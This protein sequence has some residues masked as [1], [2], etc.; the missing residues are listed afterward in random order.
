VSE[1]L[2][3]QAVHTFRLSIPFKAGSASVYGGN[4]N[5]TNIVVS[6]DTDTGIV[7]W[8]SAAFS[9]GDVESGYETIH[10]KLAPALM[11]MLSSPVGKILESLA[12]IEPEA[13]AAH[14]ALDI[15]IHDLWGKQLNISLCSFLGSYRNT[16]VTSAT[17]GQ[18]DIAETVA[19]A[20]KYTEIG[21]KALKIICGDE[22]EKEIERVKA[23]MKEYKAV[24]VRLFVGDCYNLKQSKK[25]IEAL[26]GNIELYEQAV[27][28]KTIDDFAKLAADSSVPI[29]AVGAVHSASEA[30]AVFQKEFSLIGLK[31]AECGG[32]AEAIRI[33]NIA[34][35]LGKKIVLGCMEEIPI[36]M[37]AAAHLALSHPA[38]AYT[39][40]DGH[41]H[42][43]QHAASNGIV[44]ENGMVSVVDRPGLG[45]EVRK[46]YL[47][48]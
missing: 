8:G 47:R 6:M 29:V 21:F 42:L 17:I 25:I 36:S 27:T 20:G 45:V 15:A 13:T 9:S 32:I 18:C 34:Q 12:K 38:V 26:N 22:P 43:D 40:L 23:I 41:L 24:T 44:I 2:N 3:I 1:Y 11:E 31:L 30:L 35:T 4:G 37:S 19:L 7:G 16:I 5:V 46:K 14:S 28:E 10:E 39:E 33:C 48:P